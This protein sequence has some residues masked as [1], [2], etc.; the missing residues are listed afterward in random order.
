MRF[1]LLLILVAALAACGAS[2]PARRAIPPIASVDGTPITENALSNSI[3]YATA[4]DA[5]A[6]PSGDGARCRSGSRPA[7]RTLRLQAI[8]RLIEER[9]VLRYA[10]RHHLTLDAADRAAVRTEMARLT[11]RDRP[12]LRRDV[13]RKALLHVLRMQRLIEKVERAV[14]AIPTSGPEI[15]IRELIVPEPVHANHQTLYQQAL[16]ITGGAAPP[17]GTVNLTEW[18]PRFR[19]ARPLRAALAGAHSGQYVGPFERGSSLLLIRILG[20]G[21]HIYG[22]MARHVLISR[23]FRPWLA[24]ALHQAQI[25]C[26][27]GARPA[28]A[29]GDAKMKGG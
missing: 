18:L 13:P 24:H 20:D 22:A 28:A 4:F 15:H 23:A 3:A 2:A 27:R 5:A 11:S 6:D 9:L 29:C 19:L 7:C 12:G 17:K 16:A 10:H 21:T 1:L 25:W 8:T 26:A 14:A